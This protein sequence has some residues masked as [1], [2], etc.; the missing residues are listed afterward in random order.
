[1]T[2]WESEKFPALHEYGTRRTDEAME[3]NTVDMDEKVVDD[4]E[5]M[6]MLWTCFLHVEEK[7]R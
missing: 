5:I 7:R 3:G 6:E 4:M 1:M 2:T